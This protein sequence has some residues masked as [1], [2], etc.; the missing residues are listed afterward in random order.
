MIGLSGCHSGANQSQNNCDVNPKDVILVTQVG[1]V[2]DGSFTQSAWEGLQQVCSQ[3]GVGTTYIETQD[4]SELEGNLRLAAQEGKIIVAT[5]YLF[6]KPMGVVAQEFPDKQFIL[7]DAQPT[8]GDSNP[9]TLPN[10]FSYFFDETQAGYLVGYI[11]S[12]V[13]KTNHIGFIGG[14]KSPAV[15]HFG[16]GY[17]QGAQ[18]GNP[19]IIVDYEYANSFTD[20]T[21]GLNIANAMISNG[22][23]IIFG[24]AG[25]VNKGIIESCIKSSEAGQQVW[26]IG[27]DTNMYDQGLYDNDTKSVI[28]TSAIK[29][30]GQATFDAVNDILNNNLPQPVNYLTYQEGMVGIP[31]D[32]PNLV[33]YQK[34]VDEAKNSLTQAINNNSIVNSP[35]QLSGVITITI[36]GEY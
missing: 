16:V 5:G 27:V 21:A 8:D 6:E 36:N 25:G 24:A 10:V 4:E 33:D 28:L 20:V 34:V 1:G 30:V 13:T 31:E 3:L 14:I 17:L 18:A 35:D 19:N 12:K 7:I 32:N 22:C 9:I 29:N 11:A 2:N 23:D 15:Q 26:A